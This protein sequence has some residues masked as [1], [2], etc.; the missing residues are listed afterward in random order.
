IPRWWNTS[1]GWERCC[2]RKN[3]KTLKEITLKDLFWTGRRRYGTLP[4][5]MIMKILPITFP[6]FTQ[7]TSRAKAG[8]TRAF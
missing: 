2:T 4:F 8:Y 7:K 5:G 6:F 3:H 1:E